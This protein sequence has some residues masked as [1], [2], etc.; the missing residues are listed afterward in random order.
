MRIIITGGTGMIGRELTARLLTAGHEVI[1][2][3]R[4]PQKTTG[5]PTGAQLVQWDART[6]NSWGHLADGAA[7]IVNLAGE[8]LAGAGFIPSRWTAERKQRILDSRVNSG[9]A[10]T[11]A[12]RAATTKP[13]VVIQASGSDYYPNGGQHQTETS[14]IGSGFLSDV[15]KHWEASTAEVEEMGVRRI[16]MRIGPILSMEDGAFTRLVFPFKYLIV[17]GPLG[18]GQQ[19]FPW[20]HHSDVVRAIEFFLT[21][22]AT[23]GPYNIVATEADTNG[24]FTKTLGKVMGRPSFF[25]VPGFALQLALGEVAALVLEGRQVSSQ[26]LRA[27]GFEFDYPTAEAAIRKLLAKK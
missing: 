23:S 5:L 8:N 11:E 4:N 10:V 9:K 19:H 18:G 7:A 17:G 22:P 21:H 12:V 27:A 13:G 6:A 2:L 20:V 16:V 1:I 26:K 15:V 24:T 14:P 25:P 3:T